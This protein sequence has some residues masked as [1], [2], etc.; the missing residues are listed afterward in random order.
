MAYPIIQYPVSLALKKILKDGTSGE[1]IVKENHSK[2]SLF[3]RGGKLVAAKTNVIH[4]RFGEILYKL[5]KID[6]KQFQDLSQLLEGK[7]KKIGEI[8]KSNFLFSS[9]G[10]LLSHLNMKIISFF[11]VFIYLL[12]CLNCLVVVRK[13]ISINIR[14]TLNNSTQYDFSGSIW[15]VLLKDLKMT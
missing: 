1:L 9:D 4:E 7:N 10:C 3:F 15:F 11:P 13:R 8:L 6:H 14:C 12:I 5:E 2:R